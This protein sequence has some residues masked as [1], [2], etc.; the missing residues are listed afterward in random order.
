MHDGQADQTHSSIDNKGR[1]RD[2]EKK[3]VFHISRDKHNRDI[4]IEIC[5]LTEHLLKCILT[6]DGV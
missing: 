3:K 5:L 2:H 6:L 1:Y 4:A